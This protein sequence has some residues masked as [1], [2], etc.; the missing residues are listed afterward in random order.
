MK[1]NVSS[2]IEVGKILATKTGQE[3]PDFI[4]YVADLSSQVVRALRNGLT[5][6]DNFDCSFKTVSLVSGSLAAINTGSKRPVGILP[7]QVI[8]T[9]YGFDSLQWYIDNQGQAQIKMTFTGS[10]GTASVSVVLLIV[11][12]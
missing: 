2:L 6:A 7:M 4:Q 1:I 10:P 11:Y 12:G 3:I 9:S 5:F 8:S